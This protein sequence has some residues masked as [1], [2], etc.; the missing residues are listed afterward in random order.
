MAQR[1]ENHYKFVIENPSATHQEFS[2]RFNFRPNVGKAKFYRIKKSISN[3]EA[4]AK[5][6]AEKGYDFESVTHYWHKSDNLSTFV[7]VDNKMYGFEIVHIIDEIIEARKLPK[8]KLP[9]L[10]PTDKVLNVILSDMHVGLEPNPQGRSLFQFKY[11]KEEFNYRLEQVLQ[12]VFKEFN[13]H[14]TFQNVVLY[15]LV[16]GLDGWNAETTRGGHKLDQNMSNI[17][18]FKTY[19]SG[20]LNLI[21]MIINS[22]VTNKVIVRSVSKCNHSGDFGYI[23]NETIRML[24]HRVYGVSIVQF[25]ILEKFM[26]HFYH[27]NH[28]FIITH[29]K[30]DKSMKFGMPLNLNDK[31]INYIN[32]Y[33]KHYKIDAKYIH[34]YKGDLHQVSFHKT[35]DFDYRNFPS[36]AP[37]SNWAQHNF[38]L[39]VSGYSTEIIGLEDSEVTHSDY[40]FNFEE[41]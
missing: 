2:N 33:I 25:Y 34:V 38:T 16:D 19:V 14:G 29:G 22:G 10:K 1:N 26:E 28:C 4:L 15:D 13:T 18:A 17:E 20:K 6:S 11:D 24:L 35:R 39:G 32:S 3:N 12:A 37:P 5:D 27:G 9:K 23:A 8:I 40:F 7:K 36:F 30:D 41:Q 21:E 31:T